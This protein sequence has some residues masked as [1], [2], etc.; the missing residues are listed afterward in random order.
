MQYS[1]L[2]CNENYD[3][4]DSAKA[5]TPTTLLMAM[6]VVVAC[7]ALDWKYAHENEEVHNTLFDC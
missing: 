2:Q 1:I 3:Q 7:N 4:S 6:V 5:N